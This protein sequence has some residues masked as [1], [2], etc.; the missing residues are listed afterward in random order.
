MFVIDVIPLTKIP[1]P[2]PQV[3][4]Y[5]SKEKIERGSLVRV[6]LAK[7]KVPALVKGWARLEERKIAIKKG[8]FPLKGLD[9]ILT[10]ERVLTEAQCRLAEEMGRYYLTPLGPIFKLFLPKS[11]RR[12]KRPFPLPPPPSPSPPLFPP[13]TMLKDKKVPLLLRQEDRWPFYEKEIKKTLEQK[14]QVL[15]LV[16]EVHLIEKIPP[17]LTC[18]KPGFKQGLGQLF[19]HGGLKSSEELRGWQKVKEG[20]AR[21][22]LG[23][24]SALFL[25]FQDLGLIIIEQEENPAHK[26]WDQ[27]PKYDAREGALVLANIFGAQLVLGSALPRLASFFKVERNEYQLVIKEEQKRK[28]ATDIEIVDFKKV[29]PPGAFNEEPIL[30]PRLKEALEETLRRKDQALLFINRRGLATSL[31]CRECG[32]PIKCQD[33]ALP[34]VY[35]LNR[36]RPLLL[37]HHCGQRLPPPETCP[38]CQGWQLKLLGSGTQKVMASLEQLYPNSSISRLDSDI[39]PSLQEQKKVIEEFAK[40]KIAVLVATQLLLKFSP[41]IIREPFSN[42]VG[43]VLIDPLLNLPDFRASERVFRILARLQRFGQKMIIQTY[44][45]DLPLFKHLQDEDEEAF[46]QEELKTR[47]QLAYPPFSEIIRLSCSH[48]DNLKA[49]REAAQFKAALASR[50][51]LPRATILG[52]APGF[53]PKIRGRYQWHLVIKYQGEPAGLRTKLYPLLSPDWKVE[54]NPEDLL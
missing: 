17:S 43:V 6:P 21:V 26:N 31:L 14:K 44:N 15:F 3:L 25:P 4:S 13:Q 53:Q 32:S 2:S 19:F 35:H 9:I 47:K 49:Q 40:K 22:I 42:L 48:K 46:F 20:K 1:L 52:P 27:E 16:P 11:F 50:L 23:T 37:C 33:C 39:A 10:R 38:Q 54:I 41:V 36:G 28:E 8:T 30:S 24:R 18:L 51:L 12:R 34:F 7:R 5:F 45:S 29:T